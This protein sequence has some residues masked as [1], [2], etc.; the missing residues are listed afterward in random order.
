MAQGRFVPNHEKVNTLKRA[1]SGLDAA[2]VERVLFMP[3]SG[4]LGLGALEGE[5]LSLEA[6]FV[7][8]PI[9]HEEADTSRA[10]GAMREAGASCIVTLG[11]DGT[12]RAVAKQCGDI[13]LMPLSTGTNNVFPMMLE[14]TVAGLA[15]GV[16]ATGLADVERSVSRHTR[17]EVFFDGELKDIALV[18]IAVSTERFVG[19]RAIWDMATVYELFL[20]RAEPTSIGLSAIGAQLRMTLADEPVGLYVRLGEGAGEVMA[21]VAPGLVRTVGVSEW[22]AV[23]AGGSGVSVDL[24]P[25]T[26]ALDGERAFSLPAASKVEVRLGLNGPRVI[27]PARA[28]ALAAGKAPPSRAGPAG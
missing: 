13:P 8:M 12:N 9:F 22:R 28:L 16:V 3:D 2:G 24:R 1:L 25:A 17:L 27:D 14:G 23:E 15:A 26:I 4:S 11:G 21:A 5:A 6:G 20:T 10:A 18:D 19:A 7:E